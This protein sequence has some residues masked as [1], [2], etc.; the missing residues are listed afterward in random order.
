MI[1]ELLSKASRSAKAARALLES[2]APDDAVSRAY[3]SAFNAARALIA[4]KDPDFTAKSHGSTLAAFSRL[5]VQ[6]GILPKH[7]G[8]MINRAQ[9]A[10][11][12]ADYENEGIEAADAE[13]Y[14]TFA[15]TLLVKA[16]E[17]TPASDHPPLS[18]KTPQ[19]IL[20]ETREEEAAK[21]ALAK[22]FCDLATKRGENVYPGLVSELSL[23]GTE[24]TLNGLI[25]DADEMTDLQSY[26]K[27]RVPVPSL[28]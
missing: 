28:G 27:A 6:P 1:R 19:D 17:L 21:H 20:I 3:Y 2:S 15:E 16:L 22:A 9:S 10:R 24:E 4:W 5:L 26:V 12:V 23:Y 25:A 11:Q 13:H 7:Y 14:V 8:S 18:K